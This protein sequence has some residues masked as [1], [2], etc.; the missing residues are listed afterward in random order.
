MEFEMCKNLIYKE[1]LKRWT[2]MKKFRNDVSF[3]DLLSEGYYIYAWCLKNFESGKNAKFTTYLYIQLRGRLKDYYGFEHKP[4]E[5]YEDQF[6][7]DDGF[8]D[9]SFE[10]TIVSKDY[11]IDC[12]NEELM[13]AAENSLSYEGKKVLGFI[14]SR[15]WESKM[16][17]NKPTNAQIS[18]KFGYPPEVVESVMGE[19]KMFWEKL[20]LSAA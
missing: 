16:R 2:L 10:D 5:L 4:M 17:R 19:L 6:H 14:L 7:K 11:N 18:R 9:N 1:V 15:E 8:Y 12:E 20:V 13:E 3:D